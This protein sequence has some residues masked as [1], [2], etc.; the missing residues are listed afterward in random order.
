MPPRSLLL[1][2]ITVL[3]LTGCTGNHK[4]AAPVPS[5]MK[6][7][8][9]SIDKLDCLLETKVFLW[10][11]NYLQANNSGSWVRPKYK[12]CTASDGTGCYFSEKVERIKG[13]VKM[14]NTTVYSDYVSIQELEPSEV[15]MSDFCP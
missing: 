1:I 11:Q 8:Q 6:K 3:M 2:G 10:R 14:Q 9:N 12:V 13:G 4:S 15:N 7:L 5:E